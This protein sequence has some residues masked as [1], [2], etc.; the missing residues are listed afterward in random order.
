M[1]RGGW[2]SALSY[3]LSADHSGLPFLLTLEINPQPFQAAVHNSPRG[4]HM[5]EVQDLCYL[6]I[7]KPFIIE[8][9]NRFAFL[10]I[11]R[12]QG[13]VK[14][15]QLFCPC[16]LADFDTFAGKLKRQL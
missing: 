16:L 11:K 3:Q 7:T 15:L 1:L 14:L 2:L 12:F 6:L 4:R 10:V 8:I 13:I 5:P 9:I